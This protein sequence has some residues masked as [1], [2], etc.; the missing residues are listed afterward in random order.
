MKKT[1]A[2]LSLIILTL[3]LMSCAPTVKVEAQAPSKPIE[4]NLNVKIDHEIRV[5]V[6]KKLDKMMKE[7]E[8]IF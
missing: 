5:K 1:K 6:D 8:D 4:I 2:S 3:G 7:N